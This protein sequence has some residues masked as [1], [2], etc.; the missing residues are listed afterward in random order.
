MYGQPL[1]T[2]FTS[3]NF[4]HS[5]SV[6]DNALGIKHHSLGGTYTKHLVNIKVVLLTKILILCGMCSMLTTVFDLNV[7]VLTRKQL[8]NFFKHYTFPFKASPTGFE[9]MFLI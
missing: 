4:T 1:H 2:Y 3:G 5:T 7:F 8:F 6:E 9:P